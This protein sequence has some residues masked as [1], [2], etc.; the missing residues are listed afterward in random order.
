[1]E[2]AAQ[3]PAMTRAPDRGA[4]GCGSGASR[5]SIGVKLTRASAVTDDTV[6][7][8]AG[9]Q[10]HLVLGGQGP[11]VFDPASR[12]LSHPAET[13]VGRRTHSRRARG[14]ASLPASGA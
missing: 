7:D 9:V 11:R 3:I 4:A 13:P 6:I 14:S 5:S 1:M 2:R 10:R 8:L 12:P